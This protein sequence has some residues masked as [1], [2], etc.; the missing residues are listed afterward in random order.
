ME[1][2]ESRQ[3]TGEGENHERA[4]NMRWRRRVRRRKGKAEVQVRGDKRLFQDA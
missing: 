4:G 3:E 1:G 2:S